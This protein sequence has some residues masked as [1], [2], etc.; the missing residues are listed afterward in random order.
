MLLYHGSNVE[1]K[2][3]KLLPK[4]RALDFGS[5]FY[6]TSDRQQAEKWAEL[7]TRRR[8]NGSL[9]VSVYELDEEQFKNL[10]VLSFREPNADWLE[11]VTANRLGTD[12]RDN[13]DI[14]MGPVANDNTMPVLNMYF[15]GDYTKDEAVK[16]LMAQK[17]K[18]QY[19]IKTEAA[20]AALN[21]KEVIML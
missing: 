4:V 9:I 8:K 7:M 14:V 11:Y 3:P 21:F 16:R 13:W 2:R 20:I 1:V 10:S 15:N 6:M 12:V 18:D 5:G 19:A 17:L